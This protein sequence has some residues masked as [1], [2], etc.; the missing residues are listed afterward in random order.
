MDDIIVAVSCVALLA[1]KKMSSNLRFFGK[2]NEIVYTFS[3]VTY[4]VLI[5][6]GN[7]NVAHA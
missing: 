7:S 2:K 6:D 3:S 4:M 5:S 1:K